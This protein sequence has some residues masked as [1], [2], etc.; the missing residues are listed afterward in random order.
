MSRV[1]DA[2][3]R[4]YETSAVRDE[5]TDEEAEHLLNWAEGEIRRLDAAHADDSAFARQ[6]DTLMDLL[7]SMNRFAGKQGQLSAQSASDTSGGMAALANSLGHTTSADQIAASATG[8]PTSTINR[9]TLLLGGTPSDEPISAESATPP[10]I[11]HPA[12]TP[13]PPN[14]VVPHLPHP[15]SISADPP[16][17]KS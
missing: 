13:Q 3:Q 16:G 17:D 15:A 2:L 10:P 5:L 8:D 11:L 7:R 4:I 14:A 1:D 12:Q 9:L 6:I